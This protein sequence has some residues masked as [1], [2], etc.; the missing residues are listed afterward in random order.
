Q[1]A[2]WKEKEGAVDAEDRV[3]IDFTGSVD[4]EEFEGGKA[5]D[6]V[7]AMGQGRMI[8]GFEDG[9][10]GHKAGEEFTIDVT[11]P[12]EY[13]AENLKGKAAKFV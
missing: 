4:G 10:K 9:I 8:P 13:H 2:T 7:L 6:F 1:Q 12:E 11:F 3:T 5:S